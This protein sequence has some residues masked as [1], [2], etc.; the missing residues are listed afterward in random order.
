M[1]QVFN[2]EYWVKSSDDNIT[3]SSLHPVRASLLS[4]ILL[5][6]LMIEESN[7]LMLS[8]QFTDFYPQTLL[9]DYFYRESPSS[10][11]LK[12]LSNICFTT[13]ASYAG[14]IE[15][16]LWLSVWQYYKTHK[17]II[18]EGNSL[19]N[20]TFVFTMITDITGYFDIDN[21]FLL[22]MLEKQNP[23]RLN[24][25]K[26]LIKQLEAKSISYSLVDDFIKLTRTK[27]PLTDALV[28]GA[29]TYCG[30][31]LFWYAQRGLIYV[32]Q[33]T[34]ISNGK[35]SINFLTSHTD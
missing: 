15:S 28:G 13:W 7:V 8:L 25:T 21:H 9:I 11:F 3:L 2:K 18:N 29:L 34:G 12:E 19:T 10:A 31:T 1:I 5:H 14:I 4:E 23:I 30:F 6:K 26:G 32:K 20:N 22:D 33:L 27:L 16:L 24:Q 35:K 17:H